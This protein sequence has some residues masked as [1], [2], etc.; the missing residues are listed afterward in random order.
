MVDELIVIQQPATKTIWEN[1]KRERGSTENN[2]PRL[3]SDLPRL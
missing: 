1:P 3:T 2:L